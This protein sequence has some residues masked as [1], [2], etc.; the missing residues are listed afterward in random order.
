MQQ[1][2]FIFVSIARASISTQQDKLHYA[3]DKS[4]AT[5]PTNPTSTA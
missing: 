2:L 3:A 1:K 5:A 4:L